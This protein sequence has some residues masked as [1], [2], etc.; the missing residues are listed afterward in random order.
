MRPLDVL[1]PQDV[2]Q[3]PINTRRARDFAKSLSHTIDE[4]SRVVRANLEKTMKK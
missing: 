1:T 2:R 4:A 3:Q